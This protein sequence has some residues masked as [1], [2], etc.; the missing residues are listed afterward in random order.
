MYPAMLR[1]VLATLLI[2]CWMLLPGFDLAADLK[3]PNTGQFNATASGSNPS[4]PFTALTDSDILESAA[5]HGRRYL[6]LQGRSTAAIRL[7]AAELPQKISR[8]YK[9]LRVFI[10]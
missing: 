1:R 5:Y 2:F 7:C 6:N 9:V 10:I 4:K 3:L 8:L